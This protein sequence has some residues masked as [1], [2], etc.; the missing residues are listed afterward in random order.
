MN[1]P[2]IW[3]SSAVPSRKRLDQ[4]AEY[5]DRIHL[6]WE[7]NAYDPHAFD[8]VVKGRQ[9][10]DISITDVVVDPV[11]GQRRAS[12]IAR[13]NSE[14]YGFISLLEGE[15][16]LVQGGNE[17][18]LRAGDCALWQTTRPAT[19]SSGLRTRQISLFI[20]SELVERRIPNA[21]D[22]C[23]RRFDG[24]QGFGALLRTYFQTLSSVIDDIEKPGAVHLVDPVIE[25]LNGALSGQ[26]YGQPPS[27][28]KQKLLARIKRYIIENIAEPTLNPGE[29][30]REFGFSPRYLHKV[31]GQTGQTVTGFIRQQRL[32]NAKL[33]LGKPSSRDISI[34]ELAFQCGFNDTSHFSKTFRQEFGVSPTEFRQKVINSC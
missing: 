23:G 26:Q 31:F 9:F 32:I 33:E 7:L 22:L 10:G 29:I 1:N 34:T 13:L 20:P 25:M 8:A 11:Y 12:D 30:A 6:G 2:F 14:H 15:E 18:V 16:F 5:I 4:F 24:S 3:E 21:S 28:Y 27:T 17:A 19:F